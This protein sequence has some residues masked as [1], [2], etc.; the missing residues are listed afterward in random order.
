MGTHKSIHT[1]GFTIHEQNVKTR[2]R[3]SKV[4]CNIGELNWI[5]LQVKASFYLHTNW[6][7]KLKVP[8]SLSIRVASLRGT[9]RLHLKPPPSDQLW[10]G[11]TSMPDIEFNLESSVGDHKIT[12]GNIAFFLINKFKVR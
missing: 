7:L 4:K 12:S 10:F 2:K 9:V 5:N 6:V 11:F 3:I 1:Q 8:I